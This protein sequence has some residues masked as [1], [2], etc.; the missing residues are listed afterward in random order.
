MYDTD[1]AVSGVQIDVANDH[2]PAFDLPPR[3]RKG[4]DSPCRVSVYGH[5]DFVGAITSRGKIHPECLGVERKV[6]EV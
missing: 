5:F 2:V 1:D 4:V 3:D 6:S